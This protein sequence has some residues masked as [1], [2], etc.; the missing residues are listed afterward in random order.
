MGPGMG[1]HGGGGGNGDDHATWL[2]EDDDVWGADSDAPPSVL[3]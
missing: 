2:Q 1:G 3:G